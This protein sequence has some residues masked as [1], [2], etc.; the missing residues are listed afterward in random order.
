[1]SPR[2]SLAIQKK[3]YVAFVIADSKTEVI[4]VMAVQSRDVGSLD[5]PAG[6]LRFHF[7]DAPAKMSLDETLD[8][9]E[10]PSDTYDAVTGKPYHASR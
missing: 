7:Y 1:M 10:N 8:H 2:Q 5:I 4:D 3:V 9:Q 6:A